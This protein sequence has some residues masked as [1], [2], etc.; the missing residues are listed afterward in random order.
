MN[1]IWRGFHM[2]KETHAQRVRDTGTLGGR[3]LAWP[4]VVTSP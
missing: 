4:V 1:A 3:D 2:C